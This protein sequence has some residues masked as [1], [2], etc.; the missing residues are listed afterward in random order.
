[1]TPLD[2][3]PMPAVRDVYLDE[4]LRLLRSS[5]AFGQATYGDGEWACILGH[6]G[7]NANGEPY[8]PTIR[9]ALRASLLQ[10]TG[11]WCAMQ[12]GP[13]RAE[14]EAWIADHAV[15]AP[16]VCQQTLPDA[17]YRGEFAPVLA[18]LRTRHLVVVGPSHLAA[19]PVEHFGPIQHIPVPL[20]C[21]WTVAA[22]TLE[23]VKATAAPSA[24]VLFASGMASNMVIYPLWPW[25]RERRSRRPSR[26]SSAG[27]FS[28]RQCYRRPE[29]AKDAM[30]KNLAPV[31][32]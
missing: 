3:G 24:L 14:A 20:G 28:S 7:G 13:Y 12:P 27:V 4:Y 6:Q 17:S 1:M 18:A 16:M 21:A 32:E 30:P 11:H 2:P 15:T 22:D 19:L 9:D 31:P 23:R 10:P 25:A 5:E 26:P 29:F 8:H